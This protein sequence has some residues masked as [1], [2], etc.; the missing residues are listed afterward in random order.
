[1]THRDTSAGTQTAE[2]RDEALSLLIVD[3]SPVMRNFIKRVL[4]LSGLN[5]ARVLE[6]EDGVGALETL[7]REPVDLVLADINMPRMNG[8]ELVRRMEQDD[9]LKRVPVI[10]VSTDSTHHRMESMLGH[11]VRGYI[12]K[13]FQPETLR[14]EVERVLAEEL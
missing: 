8:E 6:A 7:S 3:D 13:P 11:G 4:R 10:V 12:Q 14:A 9:R 2:T 1:V 5:I